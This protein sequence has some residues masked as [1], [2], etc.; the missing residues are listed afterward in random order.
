M[1]PGCLRSCET[2]V[3]THSLFE[4]D[5]LHIR[6]RGDPD[7]IA[8]EGSVQ[9][10]LDGCFGERPGRAVVRVIAVRLD[11][12]DPGGRGGRNEQTEDECCECDKSEPAEAIHALSLPCETGQR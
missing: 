10:G 4:S 1:L 5:I 7:L 12:D 8:G 6:P 2:T 3:E 9:A 11:V